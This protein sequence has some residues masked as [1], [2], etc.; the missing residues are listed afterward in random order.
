MLTERLAATEAQLMAMCKDEASSSLVA[1]LVEARVAA[2][3]SEYKTLQLQ[4]RY[5]ADELVCMVLFTGGLVRG[6]VGAWVAAADSE[7]KTLQLQVRW[8][9]KD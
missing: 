8:A 1:A 5:A 2:A 9:S 4:V 6:L 7:N 3:D